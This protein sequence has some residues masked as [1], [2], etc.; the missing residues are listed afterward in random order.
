MSDIKQRVRIRM[1]VAPDGRP[2]LEFLDEGG[3][4]IYSL[5]K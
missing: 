2:K 3:K 1:L 4:V 5:P